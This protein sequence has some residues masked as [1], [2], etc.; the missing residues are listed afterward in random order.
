MR[1]VI[2]QPIVIDSEAGLLQLGIRES[3]QR[4]RQAR[5]DNLGFDPVDVLVLDSFH[6]VP[7]AAARLAV[8]L[9]HVR[10]EFEPAFASRPQ[11]CDRKRQNTGSDQ[12]DARPSFIRN[13][14]WSS[15]LEGPVK[16]LHPQVR[17]LHDM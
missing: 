4:H 3:E 15:I 5:V 17:G 2:R 10:G 1:T 6:G 14:P 8:S 11:R 7:A 16:A 9:A 12:R 13:H